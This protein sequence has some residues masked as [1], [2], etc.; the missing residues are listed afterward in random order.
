M[1]KKK[2]ILVLAFML[3]PIW[4]AL[5]TQAAGCL[6]FTEAGNY[7]VC[8]DGEANF[9]AAFET[10]GLQK[11]GYPVS[12]RYERAGFVTQAF[13][14]AI[15][16]W[17]P[18]GNRVALVN[19]FD[20][21]HNDGFDQTLL[22]TRQTPKQL[23]DGWDGEGLSFEQV[24]AKRQA[25]LDTRPALRD[26][27]FSVGDPLTFYGLPTSEV[28]DMG[29]HYAARL[30]RAVLQEWKEDVPW[31]SA[32]QVTIA[33][34]G[35]IAKELGGLP[36]AALAP[37]AGAPAASAPAAPTTVPASPP[38]TAGQSWSA[39]Y[40]NALDHMLTFQDGEITM[41]VDETI[42]TS[43]GND[44]LLAF[45]GEVRGQI[46]LG[47]MINYVLDPG[48]DWLFIENYEFLIDDQQHNIS[49]DPN[50]IDLNT[51]SDGRVERYTVVAGIEEA[52]LLEAVANSETT[53]IRHIGRTH[54]E[55]REISLTEKV[56]IG[57]TL[58]AFEQLGGN[59]N[60]PLPGSVPT[61]PPAPAIDY[62]CD[63]FDSQASAQ[64]FF[65][66][67]GGPA[68]DIYDLDRDNDGQACEDYFGEPSA[69][70]PQPTATTPPAPSTGYTGPYDPFG[71]DRNCG[72]FS[73]QAD[74]QAF[75][76]A[77]G[78]PLSDRHRLDSDGNGRVC[79]SLP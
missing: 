4:S 33:N 53:I 49:I 29:N 68:T 70:A 12:R 51:T 19:I 27:Y 62:N 39:R 73:T 13:Q 20:D 56:G 46:L 10:W 54:Y 58:A 59:V 47:L 38:S 50:E 34:G 44:Q 36:T 40:P 64:S 18:D 76:E 78:G 2:L 8:D 48:Q 35:D 5:P 41:Y 43:S 60:S 61:N 74:A 65:E 75:F 28:Q 77:A 26:A 23:P 22:E 72:D 11:V 66:A 52:R 45:A 16:Q 79:E 30:Q 7:S 15:M 37:E 71:P 25:L 17:R 69:P 3:M 55:D 42:V 1:R 14:K 57:R 63:Q 32:G 31:A 21:L 9:R 6:D 67:T 24:V